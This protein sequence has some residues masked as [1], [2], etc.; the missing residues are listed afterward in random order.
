M[1]IVEHWWNGSWAGLFRRDVR[2]QVTDTG[3]WQLWVRYGHDDKAFDYKDEADAR[4]EMALLLSE[5]G[6]WKRVDSTI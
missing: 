2:L 6:P 5:E 3:T 4:T 1:N